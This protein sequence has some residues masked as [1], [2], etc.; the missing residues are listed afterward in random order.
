MG[1]MSDR[2]SDDGGSARSDA[3]SRLAALLADVVDEPAPPP[4]SPRDPAA[5]TRRVV[6]RRDLVEPPAAAGVTG[7]APSAP[8][9]PTAPPTPAPVV[10]PSPAPAPPAA[11]SARS[12]SRPAP[13]ADDDDPDATQPIPAL[14]RTGPAPVERR[15]GPSGDASSA[16]ALPAPAAPP[17]PSAPAKAPVAPA[18]PSAPAARP[19]ARR[20]PAPAADGPRDAPADDDAATRAR[21]REEE[22]LAEARAFVRSGAGAVPPG[23]LQKQPGKPWSRS[24]SPPP[25]GPPAP[26]RPTP[27]AV[28]PPAPVVFDDEAEDDLGHDGGDDGPDT[29]V[30]AGAGGRA[31]RLTL[32]AVAFG[33]AL[34]LLVGAVPVLGYVGSQRLLDSRGGQVVEGRIDEDEPGFRATITPTDTTMVVHRD[35]EGRPAAVAILALGAGDAGGSVILVPLSLQPAD[36]SFFTRIIDGYDAVEDDDGFRRSVEDVIGISVPPPLIDLTDQSLATLIAP[37][38]PLELDVSD[39]VMAD[40]GVTYDG[41]VSLA[42]EAVGPYLRATNEGEPEI[43]HLERIR[44]VWAAWLEAIGSATATEPIGAAATGMGGYLRTLAAGDPVV[45]TLDVEQ[46]DD[47]FAGTSYVPGSEM[48]DQ[49]IDAVPFPMPPRTG[50]RFLATVLN[51]ARGERLPLDLMRDIVAAGGSLTTLGNAGAF[52]Q[53]ETVILHKADVQAEA[54]A[55]QALLGDGVELEQ[56]TRRR[57]DSEDDDMIIT[58]GSDVLSRYEQEDGGG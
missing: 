36:T 12:A 44:D 8:A 20:R 32:R 50:V 46:V 23:P 49:I 16:A 51:G 53:E 52:G 26:A 10:G 17:A 57:A 33:L 22:V 47:Y 34:A 43:A 27:P 11:P 30:A 37:V 58:I 4:A 9:A 35:A 19:V 2:P 39:P 54:E 24:A 7:P 29:P 56:M 40:D 14:A 18:A 41:P 3:A 28:A 31:P 15:D 38:A 48:Q 45:E 13:A 5:P 55:L 6:R 25:P 21:Q 1:P 42:A